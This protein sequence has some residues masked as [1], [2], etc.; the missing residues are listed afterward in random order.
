MKNQF[1]M[2]PAHFYPLWWN[3]WVEGGL[4]F[5]KQVS[6][7]IDNL[8]CNEDAD[9]KILFLAEPLAILPTVSEGALKNADKFDRI[10]TFTQSILD[11]YPTA[12]LFEWGSSWLDF[13]DLKLNKKPHITFVTSSKSQTPGHNL[14]LMIM[15]ELN[16]IEEVNRMDVYAHISPPFHERRNDF[17]EN[18]MFHIATENSRQKN[19]F[20]EKVIDCFASKTIP[21]YY[22]CPNLGDWFDM[23]GVITFTDVTDLRKIFD[24]INED[25]YHSRTEVI[26]K[27]YEIAKQFHS[28]N[29][30]VPRLTR[31]IISDVKKYEHLCN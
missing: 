2:K 22:G 25:Y 4:D 12:K 29:D 10:Y 8:A 1:D 20:T 5:E 13:K 31:M 11:K 28:D 14:R 26:E 9:Y 23:D 21:I 18:A 24:R 17:F 6:I 30:V 7:S 15:R 16:Q 19:Y 27:N 3:P